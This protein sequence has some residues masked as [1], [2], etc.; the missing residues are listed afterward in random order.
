MW[1]SVKDFLL[2]GYVILLI[3]LNHIMGPVDLSTVEVPVERA[4]FP[5]P[6][7]CMFIQ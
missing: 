2:A 4:T 7:P 1:Q 6:P 3:K 5:A